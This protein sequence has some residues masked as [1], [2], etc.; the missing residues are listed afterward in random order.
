[1]WRCYLHVLFTHILL[2]FLVIKSRSFPILAHCSGFCSG[3]FCWLFTHVCCFAIFGTQLQTTSK[4]K[5]YSKSNNQLLFLVCFFIFPP[6]WQIWNMAKLV[7]HCVYP[8]FQHQ[9]P[10]ILPPA[11]LP[12]ARQS[13]CE[14]GS[15]HGTF[16]TKRGMSSTAMHRLFK[17]SLVYRSDFLWILL[18]PTILDGIAM[19]RFR[20][21]I[22]VWNTLLTEEFLEGFPV[23]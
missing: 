2:M 10:M 15:T 22:G 18:I 1:M 12:L 20:S 14:R 19:N 5:Y 3:I 17:S 9:A 6:K 23:Q 4:N 11:L 7:D 16:A 21:S 13:S 8:Q